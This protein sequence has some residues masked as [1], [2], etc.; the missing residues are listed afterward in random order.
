MPV[1]TQSFLRPRLAA[2]YEEE[3]LTFSNRMQADVRERK[4]E[5]E[6]NKKNM[7]GDGDGSLKAQSLWSCDCQTV[8][9]LQMLNM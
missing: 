3:F 7:C 9:G 1:K 4:R 6:K 8:A 5:M 2:K